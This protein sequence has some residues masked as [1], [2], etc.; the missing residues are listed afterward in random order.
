MSSLTPLR[1]QC[2]VHSQ[3]ASQW[4]S[5]EENPDLDYQPSGLAPGG[6]CLFFGVW[7]VVSKHFQCESSLALRFWS[8]I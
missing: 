1:R 6:P 8:E 4:K 3:T 7:L 2:L 5:W